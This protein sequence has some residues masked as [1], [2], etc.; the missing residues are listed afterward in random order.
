MEIRKTTYQDIDTIMRILDEARDIMRDSGNM[1]QWIEGYPTRAIIEDDASRGNSYVCVE[2]EH[3]VGTFA[4]IKGPDETY[5]HIYEGAWTDDNAPYYVVHR[6][7]STHDS[8]GIFAAAMN[9]CFSVTD[10]LRI[11]THRDNL[12]MQHNLL[13]HGFRYCGIIYLADGSERLAYQRIR[14]DLTRIAP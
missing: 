5:A 7:G 10:N 1:S 13:K 4:F 3:I 2:G 14:N 8:H 12:I 11:D 9:Y 6:M